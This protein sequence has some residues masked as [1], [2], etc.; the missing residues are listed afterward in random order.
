MNC[1]HLKEAISKGRYQWRRH[2]LE[3]LAERDILQ[4]DVLEA[5]LQGEPIED[6]P[7]DTPYPS[8]L[9]LGWVSDR[10]LHV[11]AAFD[12]ENHWAYIVTVYIPDQ[13]HFE[14]DYRTRRK[15]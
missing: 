8:A 6:Y 5:V 9:F 4:E 12:A 1:D 14:A 11:V 2:T 7:D 13:D 3:R 10:P 15:K